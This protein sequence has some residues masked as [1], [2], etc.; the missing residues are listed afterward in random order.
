MAYSKKYFREGS[1]LFKG[2]RFLN[3]M[4]PEKP[5]L[6]ISKFLVILMM[7]LFVHVAMNNPD[8][9]AAVLGAG[10]GIT[11][12][13]A[14]YGYRRHMQSKAGPLESIN[15]FEAA[16][17]QFPTV[18]YTTPYAEMRSNPYVNESSSEEGLAPDPG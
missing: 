5:V 13:L 6:S 18:S 10:F 11:A 9:L 3:L 8:N 14:N 4:E 16:S 12:S 15:E 2:L 1:F 7:W 17:P